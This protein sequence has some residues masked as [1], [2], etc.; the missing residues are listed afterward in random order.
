MI[1]M[2]PV[3]ASLAA[4]ASAHTPRRSGTECRHS[5]HRHSHVRCNERR[6]LGVVSCTAFRSVWIIR[7]RCRASERWRTR[8]SLLRLA[9]RHIRGT[10]SARIAV[11]RKRRFAAARNPAPLQV[12][13]NRSGGGPVRVEASRL[14]LARQERSRLSQRLLDGKL[15]LVSGD[16]AMSFV[17]LANIAGGSALNKQA[18]ALIAAGAGRLR[19]GAKY[20]GKRICRPVRSPGTR[21]CAPNCGLCRRRARSPA[22]VPAAQRD[23]PALLAQSRIGFATTANPPLDPKSTQSC[24]PFQAS[25]RLP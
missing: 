3:G 9:L 11:Q 10:G 15:E 25:G 2:R 4:L 14:D 24:A 20:Y 5:T 17:H 19:E 16:R 18:V 8:L 7:R 23:L 1:S 22:A 13:D 6:T 12:F 21:F